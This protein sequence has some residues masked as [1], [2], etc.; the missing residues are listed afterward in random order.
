MNFYT[1][2]S[3]VRE[4]R[5]RLYKILMVMKITTLI[6]IIACLHVSAASFAQKITL[7]EKDA[8]LERIFIDIKKQTGYIF[9]YENN[10]LDGTKKVSIDVKNA[11]IQDVL[12]ECLKNQ[13][14]TYTIAGTTIG[15]KKK[16]ESLLDNLKN[17][18]NTQFAQVTIQGKV[19][20]ETGQPMMGVTVKIKGTNTAT[21]T[22]VKGAYTITV[23]DDKTIIVFSF[24]GFEPQDFT[25]KDIANGSIIKMKA[26][27]TNLH[28]VVVSKGYYDEKRELLTGNVSTVSAK[29]IGEQPVS[30]PILALEGRVAGL[31]I[32]QTSGIPGASYTVQL[33][34][35]NSIVNGNN[36]LY[37]VDGVP[38]SPVS[39]TSPFIDGGAV[40]NGGGIGYTTGN[41]LSPF[42]NLSPS[43]IENIEVLKDADATAI[44]G[45][46]GANGVILITTKKGQAGQTRIDLD[47]NSGIGNV[48]HNIPLLNTQQYL[49]MRHE[50]FKNDGVQPT[51]SDYDV[52]GTWDTTRY[53]N[54]QKVLTG[55]TAHF[56]NANLSI[57]GGNTNTQFLLG[58]NYSR[59]T[60]VF[61]GDFNDQKASIHLNLNHFSNDQKF[62]VLF[63]AQYGQDNSLLPSTD[64][65]NASRTLA[66][67]AP[68]LYDAN[69]NINFANG[70][71]TINPITATL[72]K[73]SSI[74]NN[75]VSNFMFNY[76]IL[77]GLK[78]QSTFGYNHMEMNQS[79]Q[80]PAT[81]F[82]GVPNPAKRTN[83]IA[84]SNNNTWVIEPQI[85]YTQKISRGKIE[86]LIGT[87]VQRN[88]YNGF[89]ENTSGYA[90]DGLIQN[91]ANASTVSVGGS[92][93]TDYR[94][95]SIYG[96][97]NYVWEEKYV[98]N[99]TASRD[100]S[101]RFGPGAQF[102]NFGAVGAAWLFYKEKSITEALPF[103][104]FGK[105][106]ASY[107]TTG[108]DQIVPYQYLSS[109][110]NSSSANYQNT[111]VLSPDRIASPYYAWEV[112]K[113]LEGGVELGFLKDHI[114][115][116]VD[117]YR[118]RTGN[119]LVG[120]PLPSQDGFTSIQANLPAVVQNAGLEIELNTVN[121]KGS[122]F[123]WTTSVNFS[124]SR[125]KLV[126]FPGLEFNPSYSTTYEIGQPITYAR[127]YHFTGV[128][129]QTG[130]YTF[131]DIDGDGQLTN[132][133]KKIAKTI[134]VDYFGGIAN[135][136]SYK[137]LQLDVFIQF[138]KQTGLNGS[139]ALAGP[140][141]N[142]VPS[143]TVDHWQNPG[144]V[145]DIGKSTTGSGP[146]GTTFYANATRSD[147]I[148][149]D[150]SFIRLK[151][152][153]LSYNLPL[154][155]QQHMHLKNVRVYLQAQN[156]LTITSYKGFDPETQGTGLSP[157]RMI[158]LGIHSSL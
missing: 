123:S 156:L 19:Q 28:E 11:N 125:N 13:E 111:A 108:S 46:R 132:A 157:L 2:F 150:A 21:A 152:V 102:G 38:Y 134:A 39:L 61:P 27:E 153:A 124:R 54:W 58:G 130:Q 78:I 93:Y 120:Q 76:E 154:S 96:R 56:S 100:G 90:S 121:I 143:Y 146:G 20:D 47:I 67:D 74:T 94:A 77:A 37:I 5:G 98:I 50:A 8:P 88:T 117:Y 65:T 145:T 9:F 119:Q 87:R 32:S 41:G 80:G 95:N 4:K 62:H 149:T 52:N 40:G 35:K 129:P 64:I 44:Y 114:M 122:N 128:D 23:P 103:L 155:W 1:P 17:Q 24:V 116:N 91:I 16:E 6:I 101:S 82:F 83:R 92:A 136:F 29:V 48:A 137:G 139:M 97:L 126:S 79:E 70:T 133:D 30:D 7:K 53:T 68:P 158:S 151:N 86:V 109:Y 3:P 75:L 26:T 131:Q 69:G 55:N 22:D 31:Q 148:V 141:N 25:A 71:F 57:S 89:G 36:P 110:S 135:S 12:N 107:G 14:L 140:F 33:R 72:A 144:D 15:V 106:R 81:R 112:D 142:N 34:G 45:S 49:A 115:L 73:Y 63:T 118:N 99:A 51:A 84:T 105:L 43:D 59:Q 127:L 66:P 10:V 18:I 104:S 60:T 147:F 42:N 138:V 113:K 85:N